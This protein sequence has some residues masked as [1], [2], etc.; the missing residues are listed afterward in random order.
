MSMLNKSTTRPRPLRAVAAAAAAASLVLL[1]ACGPGGPTAPEEQ[2]PPVPDLS[3]FHDQALDWGACADTATNEADAALF[4]NP[5]LECTTVE[6]P[7]DYTKPDGNTGRVAMLRLP[8]TGE[9]EGSLLLNPGGPGGSGNNFVALLAEQW[10]ANPITERFDIVGFDP[11]GVGA[12]TPRAECFTDQE[13]DEGSGF[14]I[15]AV[16]DITSAE[17]AERAAERCV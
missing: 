12:T 8:A 13:L 1:A 2:T 11:R 10:Q 15:G 9:R 7:L 4:A 5:E 16:Y 14:R 6:V 17:Q 3:A